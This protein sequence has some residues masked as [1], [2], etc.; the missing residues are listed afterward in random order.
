MSVVD[1]LDFGGPRRTPLVRQSEASECG[2]AC[3]AMIAAHHGFE[4]D[5]P[6]LRRRFG[7]SMRGASL[8]SIMGIADRLGFSSRALRGELESLGEVQTPAIL[9]WNLNHFVVLTRVRNTLRRRRYWINDPA[10]GA[11]V[12]GEGEVSRLF[13]GVVLELT[14][15]T[16]FQP[17]RARSP[18]RIGQL[19]SSIQGAGAA[20]LGVLLLSAILQLISLVM[21]FYLQLGLDNVLPASDDQLLQTL[22][23]GFGGLALVNVLTTWLRSIALLNMTN[24]FSF[25]II[26]N[27][28]R[29]LFSLPLAW[30][31]K[32][33]VGDVI[34]RFGSTQPITDFVSQGMISAVIDGGMAFITL[35][36]MFVYSPVL[37]GVA[38]GAW[39]LYV[40]I[41]VASF[42]VMRASNVSSITANAK[43]NSAFIESVRGVSTIKAFGHELGR[44]RTWQTLKAAAINAS[45]KLGRITSTFEAGS[46][47][48]MAGERVLFVYL[49]MKLA[50][51]GGFTVGMIFA[52]QAYKQQFLDAANRLADQALKYRLIDVHLSRIADIA[53]SRPEPEG[54]RL[55]ERSAF[56]GAIE[57]RGVSF[58]YGEGD[59]FVL[60]NVSL[61]IEPGEMVAFVGPSGGG[62][63]TLLKLI[64]GLLEPTMGTVLVDGQ[65]LSQVGAR[66]WRSRIGSVLQDG[67]LFAGS[68]AENVALFEPEIDMERVRE[69]C[70]RA[71]VLDEIETM[72]LG[73]ETLVGD[74]GSSLSGG[75][76][77]R[78]MLARAF[79]ARPD[80]LF[81]DEGTANLDLG[82]EAAIVAS[83]REET[84]TRLV[85][86]H[87]PLAVQAASR[88]IL[89]QQGAVTPIGPPTIAGVRTSP[90]AG[91]VPPRAL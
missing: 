24:A 18:L 54:V 82:A 23:I 83:L 40:A 9:H 65:P 51:A 80:V 44:Q 34:S 60:R 39:L 30:F 47:A 16:K 84:I 49:A 5:M 71:A 48:I 50:M 62:K 59:P 85:S 73:L 91:S 70:R 74:M 45:L 3:L 14:K 35:V 12:L 56:T 4:A 79:Y 66:A 27:L 22:A 37:A 64:M 61:A 28:Y 10:S 32:R 7:V 77:Q 26:N 8:K 75:Q 31:E 57:L 11:R 21:P 53:L 58:R 13:T 90:T 52:F 43:E 89:V 17:Q 69:A 78:V 41:K 38:V 1:L 36:L 63:T 81:M 55:E 29:H 20:L 6:T 86:A 25:Q 88:V 2:L 33:H 19:W 76:R 87:R 68:I 15:T 46:G 42:S 72:P 67:Q